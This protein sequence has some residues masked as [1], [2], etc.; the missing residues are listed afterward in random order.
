MSVIDRYEA[1]EIIHCRDNI[2]YFIEN[3]LKIRNPNRGS[4]YFELYDFQ[5][6]MINIYEDHKLCIGTVARQMGTTS[7]SCAYILWNMIFKPDFQAAI[8]SSSFSYT[9][10]I[11]D[12]VLFF[13][14]NLPDFIKV[15]ATCRNKTELK[16][17]NGSSVVAMTVRSNYMRGRTL[18]LIYF[19]EMAYFDKNHADDMWHS[20]M[21]CIVT[22]SQ[23]IVASTPNSTDNLFYK[24][25]QAAIEGKNKFHPFKVIW[26]KH[27]D[28]NDEFKETIV[29]T[30]GLKHFTQEYECEFVD[31]I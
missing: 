8:V 3:Y 20:L 2:E 4:V 1:N 16:L 19:D 11:M 9:K 5:K 7:L 30:I 24:I 28:R 6:D 23:V 10:E 13:F 22:G 27:P 14:D 29:Q 21:P 12:R 25:W 31:E 17:S 26:N 15:D 18:N